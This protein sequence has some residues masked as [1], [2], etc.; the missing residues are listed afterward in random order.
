MSF[1]G[2]FV[3]NP[4]GTL[5]GELGKKRQAQSG[6]ADS[7][8][9]GTHSQ[10]QTNFSF[11][12]TDNTTNQQSLISA[13]NN[14]ASQQNVVGQ[15]AGKQ[16]TEGGGTVTQTMVNEDTIQGV[17]NQIMGKY[18]G[19]AAVS[20]GQNQA[21]LYNSTARESQANDLVSQVV[22]KVAQ[23][24]SPTI[25]QN[26]TQTV[27]NEATQAQTTAAQE[28]GSSSQSTD[29]VTQALGATKNTDIASATSTDEEKKHEDTTGTGSSTGSVMD[30]AGGI[31]NMITN[32]GGFSKKGP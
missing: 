19:L 5:T 10:N 15:Q 31:V 8:S 9:S 24:A 23:I 13:I 25:T 3:K 6:T 27:S 20:Q 16:V 29:A 30:V 1:L 32:P 12:S 7:T 21:G 26:L 11:G 2:N 28:T 17:I 18:Q 22:A 4:L 14:S